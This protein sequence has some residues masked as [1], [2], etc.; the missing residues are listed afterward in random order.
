MH[1]EALTELLKDQYTFHSVA[2]SIAVT[3]AA[4]ALGSSV[5]LG[6]VVGYLA[7]MVVTFT[8]KDKTVAE[9]LEVVIAHLTKVAAEVIASHNGQ[10]QDLGDLN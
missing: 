4:N 2:F 3:N 9:S 7:E 8:P 10:A 1:N 5:A 6:I